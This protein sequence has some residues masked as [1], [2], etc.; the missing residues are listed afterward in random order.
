MILA[1]KIVVV[2]APVRNLGLAIAELVANSG[3]TATVGWDQIPNWA[4]GVIGG[5]KI[6]VTTD[7]TKRGA[8]QIVPAMAPG[9]YHKARATV[10]GANKGRVL[11]GADTDPATEIDLDLDDLVAG[12]HERDFI[13][14]SAS[15]GFGLSSYTALQAVDYDNVSVQLVTSNNYG[16]NFGL[17]YGDL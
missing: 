7:G 6:T 3:F 8:S 12:V 10:I 15:R 11:V 14:R 13:P 16:Y 5:G 1:Q 17:G 2:F 9:R 4:N